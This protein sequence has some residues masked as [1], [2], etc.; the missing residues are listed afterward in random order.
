MRELTMSEK[1]TVLARIEAALPLLT[2]KN[3]EYLFEIWPGRLV[4]LANALEFV[5]AGDE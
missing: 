4:E 5:T 1:L 3:V 2:P